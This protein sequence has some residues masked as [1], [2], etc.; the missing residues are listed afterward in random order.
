MA[1]SPIA[2]LL[3]PTRTN[4]RKERRN[5]SVTPRRFGRFF[6][7]R[8]QELRGRRIL[9]T[10]DT[11]ATNQQ[12]LSPRMLASDPLTPDIV[13]SSPSKSPRSTKIAGSEG[14]LEESLVEERSRPTSREVQLPRITFDIGDTAQPG[15]DVLGDW[16]KATLVRQDCR[17]EV[18]GE[19]GLTQSKS[20]FFKASRGRAPNSKDRQLADA[21]QSPTPKRQKREDVVE[22]H[23]PIPIKKFANMGFGAQMLNRE[24]G[25]A[26]DTGKQYLAYPAWDERAETANFCSTNADWYA[27]ESLVQ[28]QGNPLPFCLASCSKSP[29]TAIGD[30]QGY[31]R[32]FRTDDGH[33]RQD[34]VYETLLMHDNAVI[35]VAFSQDDMRLATAAGD[36]TC[37]IV[38]VT[39]MKVAVTLASHHKSSLRQVA[40]QPGQASGDVLAT[41]DRDGTIA[42]WDLRCSQLPAR[43]FSS[44]VNDSSTRR[45]VYPRD[46]SLDTVHGIASNVIPAAHSRMTEGRYTPAS[47]TAIHW[48]PDG[49]EH[50]LLSGS[51]ANASIRLWDTRYIKPVRAQSTPLAQTAAPRH[52]TFRSYGITSIAMSSDAARFY[53]VCRDSTVYAYSTAHLMLGEAPELVYNAI[54]RKPRATEGIGPLFGLK[55][56]SFSVGTFFIKSKLRP[57]SG[58]SPELLAVGSTSGC[59]MLFSTDER[60]MRTAW[61]ANS[62]I[63]KPDP[64]LAT[65]SQSFTATNT[66]ASL[67]PSNCD[68]PIYRSGTPLVRGHEREV[69]NV[70]WTHQGR[71]VTASDDGNVRHWQED[72]A[73]ARHLR[74]VGDFGGERWM[75]G[76]ADVGDEW[77]LDDDEL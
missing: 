46:D 62:H 34:K 51:E 71:L 54:K 17:D 31:V 38:D 60:Y 40:F 44:V 73:K 61:A 5:P 1:S 68:I 29:V 8:S 14:N 50:L 20:Q 4:R 19:D 33:D 48:F 65:P 67:T 11:A 64:V 21:S 74:Q 57:A 76:W 23:E 70:S 66:P 59:P 49:R 58:S 13:L 53:A 32:L 25:F 6:T 16:R 26:M 3:S 55:N 41:S 30:E 22:T 45:R 56:E 24:H 75:S 77:D 69:T 52:H 28:G 10:L 35:D 2:G 9:A 36:R 39:T 72:A 63:L 18:M 47:L 12:P 27:N 43:T 42:I 37:G 15:Q 7:P